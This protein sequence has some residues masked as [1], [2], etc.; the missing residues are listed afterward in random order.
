MRDDPAA[1]RALHEISVAEFYELIGIEQI[2]REQLKIARL[3]ARVIQNQELMMGDFTEF[4]A[5]L[6]AQ[7]TALAALKTRI[8]EDTQALLDQI[9]ALSLDTADQAQI[10]A[11]AARVQAT[12]EELNS[13]DPV[14]SGDVPTP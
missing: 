13:I 10:D 4:N 3:L 14:T 2:R 8:A 12:V 6:D 5:K 7:A 1:Q 11:A 9:A